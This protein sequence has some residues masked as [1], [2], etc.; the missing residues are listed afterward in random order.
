LPFSRLIKSFSNFSNLFFFAKLF[1]LFTR[2]DR[3]KI[4]KKKLRGKN[5]TVGG[6]RISTSNDQ[7]KF[8]KKI[9]KK[10]KI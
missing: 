10:K 1:K 9:Q 6:K 2:I 7:K 3:K 5:S 8:R 4:E